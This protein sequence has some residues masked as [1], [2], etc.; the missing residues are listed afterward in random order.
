[1]LFTAKITGDNFIT[2][3]RHQTVQD[4]DRSIV[5]SIEKS[6]NVVNVYWKK[7]LE[8]FSNPIWKY[9][10]LMVPGTG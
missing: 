9:C 5:I 7:I 4:L 6:S 1:M 2:I 3:S 8:K 10:E